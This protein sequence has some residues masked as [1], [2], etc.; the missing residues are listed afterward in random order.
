[1]PA[2]EKLQLRVRVKNN[3]DI[4]WPGCER[5]AGQFQIYLGSHWLNASRQVASKEEGRSPL[6]ADLAPGQ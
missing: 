2:G 6:P 1:V 3:G 5:S 4:V